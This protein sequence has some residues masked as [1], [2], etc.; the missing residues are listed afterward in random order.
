[1]VHPYGGGTA[2]H[3]QAVSKSVDLNSV[4]DIHAEAAR[5]GIPYTKE[6]PL[7]YVHEHA[8][9]FVCC[10]TRTWDET[11]RLCV[12]T[13]LTR[14]FGENRRRMLKMD[15]VKELI[16]CST[17]DDG[18][19]WSANYSLLVDDLAKDFLYNLQVQQSDTDAQHEVLSLLVSAAKTATALAMYKSTF[20]H[21]ESRRQGHAA[22]AQI[23]ETCHETYLPPSENQPQISFY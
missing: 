4:T 16:C 22:I 2:S 20:S 15:R 12:R 14:P 5:R 3:S 6:Q 9:K 18:R 19:M 11:V 13:V 17:D 8:F 21:Y 10:P 1:M 7:W 23:L